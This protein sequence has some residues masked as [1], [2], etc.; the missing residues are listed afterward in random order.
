V[1]EQTSVNDSARPPDASFC[2]GVS[3]VSGIVVWLASSIQATRRGARPLLSGSSTGEGPS[4]GLGFRRG[5][6]VLQAA[7]SLALLCG[8]AMLAHSLHNLTSV[9][10]GFRT[11]GLTT[12]RLQP[13]T[14]A[15]KAET[16]VQPLRNVLDALSGS[17]GVTGAAATTALPA[18]EGGG[19]T[20]A[21]GGH[22]PLNAENAV[23]VDAV[24]VTPGFFSTIGVPVIR[25]RD[26]SADDVAGGPPVAVINQSPHERCSAT[27]IR[28]AR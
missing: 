22:V 18:L 6:L 4:H 28:S 8:A 26:L 1:V 11:T 3:L 15:T 12:F 14:T 2:R 7:L 5:L 23:L 13:A 16:F 25:G 27:R 21:V 20:W 9:D 24:R 17:S 10:P 19:G